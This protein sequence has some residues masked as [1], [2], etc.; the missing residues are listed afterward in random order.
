MANPQKENG[1]TSI[2]NEIME[3][4][5]KIR[6]SSYEMRVLFAILRKT[7]GWNK[8]RDR[9]SFSQFRELTNLRDPH[10]SRSLKKLLNRSIVTQI[11]KLYGLQKDYTKWKKLPKLVSGLTQ[12]GNKKL[13]ELVDTITSKETIQKKDTKVSVAKPRNKDLDNLIEFS[14]ENNFPLQGTVRGNRYSAYNLLKNFGLENTLAD[15]KDIQT[16]HLCVVFT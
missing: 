14:K 5:S 2:A 1:F 9:I 8:K 6:L 16:L 11:G 4:L 13:P 7:Y 10:I 15:M 3:A 12:N